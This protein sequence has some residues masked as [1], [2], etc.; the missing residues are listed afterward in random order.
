MV[1]CETSLAF[2]STVDDVY[3]FTPWNYFCWYEITHYCESCFQDVCKTLTKSEMIVNQELAENI[4]FP[5][6]SLG[7]SILCYRASIL[8]CWAFPSEFCCLF[9][10]P[11]WITL[12]TSV[13]GNAAE[14]HMLA[15][16]AEFFVLGHR[17][18]THQCIKV[19]P[20]GLLDHSSG[21]QLIHYEV[22]HC[23][24]LN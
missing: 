9:S 22:S 3:F 6:S 1:K 14:N 2:E 21:T 18:A 15:I 12:Q 7:T 19:C 23:L 16:R 11:L 17:E 10:S 4:C 24:L 20:P 8:I 5:F 13:N